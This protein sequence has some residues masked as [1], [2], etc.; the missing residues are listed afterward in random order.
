MTVTVVTNEEAYR[1]DLF[2]LRNMG[3][4]SAMNRT[5]IH[6]FNPSVDF[7]NL[8]AGTI[9]QVPSVTEMRSIG[10]PRCY[11]LNSYKGF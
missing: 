9:L 1:V 5:Y 4:D 6:F 11:A 3:G 7:T 2:L 10:S 8:K